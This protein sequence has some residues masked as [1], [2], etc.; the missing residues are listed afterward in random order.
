MQ[1]SEWRKKFQIKVTLS[2]N[3][4]EV[5]VRTEKEWRESAFVFSM[6]LL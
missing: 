3:E 2:K 5:R 4:Q 1:K 6:A